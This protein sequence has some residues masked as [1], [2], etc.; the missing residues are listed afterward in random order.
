MDK[1]MERYVAPEVEVIECQVEK[2]YAQSGVSETD[3]LLGEDVESGSTRSW[4]FDK[5]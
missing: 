1:K 2:G 5:E 4:W 3:L